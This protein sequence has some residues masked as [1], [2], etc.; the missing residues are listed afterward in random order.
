MIM[1]KKYIS[2]CFFVFV[3]LSAH[4]Q[5]LNCQV[6]VLTPQLQESNKTIYETLQKDIR[7]FINNKK[8]TNDQYLNQERIECSIIININE[9]VSTD[10]FKAN[11]QIQSRRPVFGS[12]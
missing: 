4:A 2:I 9:R 7:E 12:S 1:F 5:E 10:E 3:C 11:I 8:W 6:S